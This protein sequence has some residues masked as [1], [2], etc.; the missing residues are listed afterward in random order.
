MRTNQQFRGLYQFVV[1]LDRA[2][3]TYDEMVERMR[4]HGEWGFQLTLIAYAT[5]MGAAILVYP[6]QGDNIIRI[7]PAFGQAMRTIRLV[8]IPELHYM[9]VRL[10]QIA[11]DPVANILHNTRMRGKSKAKQVQKTKESSWAPSK[12]PNDGHLCKACGKALYGRRRRW[13]RCTG[14]CGA[15]WHPACARR[16]ESA[17]ERRGDVGYICSECNKE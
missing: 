17:A 9:A 7:A 10:R 12:A 6:G 8:H 5:M 4:R 2:H 13:I 15:V 14:P 11:K 16:P 3:E 1:G